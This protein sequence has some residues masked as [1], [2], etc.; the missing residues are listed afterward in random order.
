VTRVL[1][2]EESEVRIATALHARDQVDPG[3]AERLDREYRSFK[4]TRWRPADDFPLP[5]E[6][7]RR[8]AGDPDPRM[9]VLAP[10]DPE[11]PP[12]LALRLAGDSEA[13]VRAAIAGHTSLPES[14]LVALLADPSEFV[15]HKAAAN[16]SL[17]LHHMQRLLGLAGL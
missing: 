4:K 10:R 8:L 7:L 3:T 15:A 12:E 14:E 17:P 6:T 11:L 1:A 5:P 13:E 16:P 9:R 2:D